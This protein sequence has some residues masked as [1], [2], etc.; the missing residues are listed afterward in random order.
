MNGKEVTGKY[1]I[2][3]PL[4]D[5]AFGIPTDVTFQIFENYEGNDQEISQGN[6]EAHKMVLGLV[7]PVF[8]SEFF[9]PAKETKRYH[10]R[11]ANYAEIIQTIDR[12]YIQHQD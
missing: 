6:V 7:S 10:P 4:L 1:S 5:P 8:K 12:L 9:G 3:T 2:L 11:K